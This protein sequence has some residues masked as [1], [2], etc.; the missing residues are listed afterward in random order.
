[1]ELKRSRLHA[2]D[3]SSILEKGE[4]NV[5]SNWLLNNC[6]DYPPSII[7]ITLTVLSHRTRNPII[8]LTQQEQL[9]F[10]RG[11]LRENSSGRI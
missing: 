5:L 11:G 1:M 9:L 10:L 3:L 6:D 8:I 4:N 2:R 7:N